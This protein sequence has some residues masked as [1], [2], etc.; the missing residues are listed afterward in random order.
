MTVN[1]GL[2]PQGG[3]PLTGGRGWASRGLAIQ[4][5]TVYCTEILSLAAAPQWMIQKP[6]KVG[7]FFG[8]IGKDKFGDILKKKA[9][10]G[11]VDAHYYEQEEEPTGTCAVCITGDKRL[12]PK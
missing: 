8:C 11:K 1:Y 6:D 5:H 2:L 9:L 10:E 12:D 4:L 3:T 7:T